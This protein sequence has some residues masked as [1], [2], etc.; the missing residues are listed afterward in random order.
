M[1]SP[2]SAQSADEE[3][4]IRDWVVRFDR[5]RRRLR[6]ARTEALARAEAASQ[7]A[8]NICV[9]DLV[10]EGA[11]PITRLNRMNTIAGNL[12]AGNAVHGIDAENAYGNVVEGNV[13]VVRKG[14]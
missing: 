12:C 7:P 11:K 3:G 6:L 13:N 1:L 5:G 14:P 10:I 4:S 2:K 8:D 9:Q